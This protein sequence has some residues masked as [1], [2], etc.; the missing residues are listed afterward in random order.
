MNTNREVQYDA[1][2]G[3]DSLLMGTD[4]V[5]FRFKSTTIGACAVTAS[6][7]VSSFTF[8]I[9]HDSMVDFNVI[10][11]PPASYSYN[12]DVKLESVTTNT[13]QEISFLVAISK[14]TREGTARFVLT[15]THTTDLFTSIVVGDDIITPSKASTGTH[16]DGFTRIRKVQCIEFTGIDDFFDWNQRRL[17]SF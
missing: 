15:S 11:L 4:D 1:F 5:M 6:V 2:A 16:V 7:M 14:P 10:R 3:I 12:P 8:S 9:L 17:V 13:Y